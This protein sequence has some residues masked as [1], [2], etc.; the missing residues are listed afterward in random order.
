MFKKQTCMEPERNG[1]LKDDLRVRSARNVACCFC[2]RCIAYIGTLGEDNGW[3][4]NSSLAK[5]LNEYRKTLM[6]RNCD[7]S[8]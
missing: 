3:L 6:S 5:L 1:G 7:D 2:L 4:E 8:V